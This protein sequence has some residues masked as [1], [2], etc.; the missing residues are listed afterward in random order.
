L[1]LEEASLKT[2]ANPGP[3]M[4]QRVKFYTNNRKNP[5]INVD[6]FYYPYQ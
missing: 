2:G 5:N 4:Q 1:V 6:F 3:V